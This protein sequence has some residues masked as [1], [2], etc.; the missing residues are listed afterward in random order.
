MS[1]RKISL[2][3]GENLLAEFLKYDRQTRFVGE[4]LPKVDGATMFHA[5]E[6]RSPFLDT[7]LWD[8]AAALPVSLRLQ[9][10]ELKAILRE[11]VRRRIS[12]ELA[13]GKKQGFGIPVQRWL[14]GKWK[15][16]FIELMN[17]SISTAKGG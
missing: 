5:L 7:K 2:T 8:F 4:Y 13:D 10:G 16:Q 1:H 3:S 17:N 11:I 6:S 15:R 12:P 14:V 9:N